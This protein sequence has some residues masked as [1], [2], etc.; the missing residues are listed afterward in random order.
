MRKI[1]NTGQCVHCGR[2]TVQI[3][4]AGTGTLVCDANAVTYWLSK[5]PDANIITPNGE[6]TTCTLRGT[7]ETAHGIGHA[8][9][10]CYGEECLERGKLR[11][12]A[13][14]AATS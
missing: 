1:K 2:E 3:N 6:R 11:K 9:H 10:K 8:L 7:L 5:N 4:V 12:P 14:S 13:S